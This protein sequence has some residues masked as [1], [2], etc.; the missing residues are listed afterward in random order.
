M[1]AFAV[2]GNWCGSVNLKSWLLCP[3]PL[4]RS[5][6]MAQASHSSLQRKPNPFRMLCDAWCLVWG[7]AFL[8]WW[9]YVHVYCHRCTQIDFLS[10]LAVSFKSWLKLGR[11]NSQ[12][13]CICHFPWLKDLRVLLKQYNSTWVIFWVITI[14]YGYH[15]KDRIMF[16]VTFQPVTQLSLPDWQ[17][18]PQR[19]STWSF[20]IQSPEVNEEHPYLYHPDLPGWQ[21]EMLLVFGFISSSLVSS[22]LPPATFMGWR[23]TAKASTHIYTLPYLT[24]QKGAE[25]SFGVW[26]IKGKRWVCLNKAFRVEQLAASLLTES[27]I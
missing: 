24:Q 15:Q 6:W 11:G 14:R 13:A 16:P 26:I 27:I 2:F 7:C 12:E 10:S 17:K 4:V 22:D 18:K 25:T 20:E 3:C 21:W 19:E 5:G 8:G 1:L 9:P 23:S